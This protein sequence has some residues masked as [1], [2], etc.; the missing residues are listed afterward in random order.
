MAP[1]EVMSRGSYAS[2][3]EKDIEAERDKRHE[4]EKQVEE[5]KKMNSEIGSMLGLK[6]KKE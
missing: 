2:K 6:I 5:L 1:S 4:L 3:L